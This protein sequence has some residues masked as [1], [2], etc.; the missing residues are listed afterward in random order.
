MG[1]SFLSFEMSLSNAILFSF[2]L[3]FTIIIDCEARLRHHKFIV[4]EASYTRLCETKNILTVN[5]QF[6]GPTL[7]AYEGETIYVK[8]YNRGRQ[9]ITIHWHGVKQPR[10]P[11]SDG[12]QYITQCPIRPGDSFNYKIIFSMEIGTLWWHAHSDWSRATVH[13]PI[14]VYP[15]HGTTYPFPKP[16]QEV[17]I[18]F[19]EWWKEDIIK[20]LREFVASGGAPRL[21]DAYTINGQPGD[22]YP[23]SSQGTFNLNVTYGKRYLLRI[24]NA[25][26]DEI[27]FFAIANHSLTVVGADA[28][29]TKPFTTEYVVISPGQ[30]LDCLLEANQVPPRS[31]Y[32]MAARP[33]SSNANVAFDNTTTTGIL[34][35]DSDNNNDNVPIFPSSLPFYTDTNAA[36]RFLGGLKSLKPL[37]FPL[38]APYDTQIISTVS[39]NT[40]PCRNNSC[41]GPNGSRTWVF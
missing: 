9:N 1:Q 11:W 26:M 5:G 7:Y 21:S 10:N 16:H 38:S 29:Y 8:V 36:F 31:R 33:Y 28:S 18:I 32:Y 17:P 39:V 4:R 37:L 35:Y 12:P 25:A 13:G 20:V 19:G 27:L 2:L 22:L 23:C 14:I 6:P 3:S 30:T 40:L 34:H 15:K 41:S 24:V